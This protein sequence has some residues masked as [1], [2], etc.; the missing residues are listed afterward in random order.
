MKIL[1]LS[2]F[3]RSA[4]AGLFILRLCFGGAMAWLH[5]WDKIKNFSGYAPQFMNF[6]GIGQTPSLVLAICGEFVCAILL[7]LGLFTRLAALGSGFTMGVAFFMAHGAKLKGEG[8]GEMALLYLG[9]FF[10]LFLAGAGRFS[11]DAR[12][13]VR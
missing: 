1:H 12:L 4:D 8:S 9:A 6:M 5:G 3:P 7:V 13:G 2:F 11:A 10:V